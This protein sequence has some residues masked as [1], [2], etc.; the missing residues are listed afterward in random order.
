MNKSPWW[1]SQST[2][3]RNLFLGLLFAFTS[4]AGAPASATT[5]SVDQSDLWW[6]PGESG[7]GLQ[8]VQRGEVIFSTMF[9]YDPNGSPIWFTATM[10]PQA[11]STWSGELYQTTGTW[12]L[13]T[14]FITPVGLRR[15]GTMT[16]QNTGGYGETGRLTYTVDGPLVVKNVVRQ[17]IAVDNFAGHYAATLS[18]GD[19]H[20]LHD[21]LQSDM[22]ITQTASS[23]SMVWTDAAAGNTC[24]MTGPLSQD[25]QFGK[26]VGSTMSCTVGGSGTADLSELSVNQR[27]V[28]GRWTGLFSSPTCPVNGY[29]SATRRGS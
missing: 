22:R 14:P 9:V 29:F 8:L 1:S 15:V 10:I 23:I 3:V 25:G 13:A 27:S 6:N 26:A 19:C 7:W 28:T 16:W 11:G 18:Y 24:T 2:S 4:L 12:Y 20:G 5:F 21:V 17:F